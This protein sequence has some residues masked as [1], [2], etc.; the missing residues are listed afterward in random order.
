MCG[1]PVVPMAARP[2]RLVPRAGASEPPPTALA[3]RRGCS[4]DRLYPFIGPSSGIYVVMHPERGAENSYKSLL[5]WWHGQALV[6]A[7]L[8]IF[9]WICL[10][11]VNN[12]IQ[13]LRLRTARWKLFT[14]WISPWPWSDFWMEEYGSAAPSQMKCRYACV[15]RLKAPVFR[16]E[17]VV[18]IEGSIL[19]FPPGSDLTTSMGKSW[20]GHLLSTL[21][22][23]FQTFCVPKSFAKSPSL[24]QLAQSSGDSNH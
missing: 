16:S 1:T 14:C 7:L 15:K 11:D 2:G 12:H 21:A 19:L 22:I 20:Y 6:S 23:L 9:S 24:I 13:H 18:E 17:S 10:L 4:G 3:L 5:R 8:H